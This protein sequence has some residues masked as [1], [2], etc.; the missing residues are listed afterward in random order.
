MY[1]VRWSDKLKNV[2]WWMTSIAILASARN[3][4]CIEEVVGV[5][6]QKN[7]CKDEPD[8]KKKS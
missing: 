5:S 6:R 2:L 4:G 1:G 3:A 7:D 8:R